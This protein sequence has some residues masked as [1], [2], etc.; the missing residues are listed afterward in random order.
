MA[1]QHQSKIPSDNFQV[2]VK[3][4]PRVPFSFQVLQ[5]IEHF[6]SNVHTHLWF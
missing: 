3:T 5:A 4:V 2:E 6:V 1:Q